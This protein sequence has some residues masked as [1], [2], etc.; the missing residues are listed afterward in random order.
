VDFRG[1]EAAGLRRLRFRLDFRFY[2]FIFMRS[3]WLPAGSSARFIPRYLYLLASPSLSLSLSL[4][5]SVSLCLS[6]SLA[7]ARCCFSRLRCNARRRV[8]AAEGEAVASSASYD[9]RVPRLSRGSARGIA[10][11]NDNYRVQ[12]RWKDQLVMPRGERYVY[13]YVCRYARSR[14]RTKGTRARIRRDLQIRS[15]PIRSSAAGGESDLRGVY[16]RRKFR[17]TQ[18]T[19]RAL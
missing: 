7:R 1:R 3:F 16:S 13:T 11:V 5:L 19:R 17:G 2:L 14:D 10:Y 18:L 8:A 4:S 6:L 12:A 9:Q 15:D